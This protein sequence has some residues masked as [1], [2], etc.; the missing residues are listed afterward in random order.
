MIVEF[1]LVIL[2]KYWVDKLDVVGGE[3]GLVKILE[4]SF[5]RFILVFW[6][7]GIN[8]CLMLLVFIGNNL[9]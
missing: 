2:G 9:Y 1:M 5:F 4:I 6:N 3:G 7:Y 8:K